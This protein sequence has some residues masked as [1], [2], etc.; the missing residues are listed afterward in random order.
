MPT[1]EPSLVRALGAEPHT[2]SA[3]AQTERRRDWHARRCSVR[4]VA[5]RKR[6]G[7]P[8]IAVDVRGKHV[9]VLASL[10]PGEDVARILALLAEDEPNEDVEAS[11]GEQQEGGDERERLDIV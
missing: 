6:S 4:L 5:L 11:S 1:F 3:R 10:A 2:G 7:V 9:V 8:T